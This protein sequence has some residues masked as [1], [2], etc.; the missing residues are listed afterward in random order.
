MEK[1]IIAAFVISMTFFIS[2]SKAEEK[3]NSI[4]PEEN[5]NNI[6]EPEIIR[7]LQTAKDTVESSIKGSLPDKWTIKNTHR[8]P[9]DKL[10]YY[11]KTFGGNLIMVEN[12][13]ISSSEPYNYYKF[14]VNLFKSSSS[15]EA[16]KIYNN[17][18]LKTTNKSKYLLSGDIVYEFMANDDY[19]EK[20]RSIFLPDKK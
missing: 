13:F 7:K 3:K 2:C 15:T 19:I 6:S 9:D 17:L 11:S 16:E 1:I 5:K 14:Q 4:R 18:I 12:N 8:V 20:C 10:D